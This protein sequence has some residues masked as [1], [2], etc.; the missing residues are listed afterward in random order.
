MLKAVV[1][2]LYSCTL[3][4]AATLGFS[5]PTRAEE[6]DIYTLKVTY[7]SANE[8][9]TT[10]Q[11]FLI[12][13]GYITSHNNK[14]VIRTT[15]SNYAQLKLLADELDTAPIPLM[16]SVKSGQALNQTTNEIQINGELVRK[17]QW[18]LDKH[19]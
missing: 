11:P 10:L 19:E 15:A 18:L 8:L 9:I 14:L 12:E 2:L 3:I 13:G 16:I 1:K 17:K 5:Y 6:M 4:I 7:Q